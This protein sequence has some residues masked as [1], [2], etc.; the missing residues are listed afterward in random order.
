MISPTDLAL[1]S[2]EIASRALGNTY[3]NPMVGC[4][5]EADGQIIAE[6]Y[7]HQSGQPHAEVM[8]IQQVQEPEI[9][10]K[11]T[12]FVSLEPCVHYG[13]TPPCTDLIIKM[14]IPRVVVCSQDPN[15]NVNGKG[16]AALQNAGVNVVLMQGS[17]RDKALELNKRFFCFHKKSRPYII[18]KWA[19]THDGF[20]DHNFQSLA[21]SSP[22]TNQ[23]THSL[24][25]SEHAILVGAT[26]ALRDRPSLSTRNIWGRDPIRILLDSNLSSGG[27]NLLNKSQAPL[28]II[29]KKEEKD[30]TKLR[31]LKLDNLYNL[32]DLMNLFYQN[33]IQSIL[34]EGGKKLLQS[35]IDAGLW[36]EAYQIT[37]NISVNHGTPAPSLGV[38]AKRT[39]MS[40]TDR[41][42]YFENV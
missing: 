8:A 13:K 18:L 25:A 38:D 3:P 28:W 15:S 39:W 37:A 16:I 9:L 27:E 10:K 32:S 40:D 17:I 41:I 30:L 36:D 6:G 29:N 14:G 2:I 12:L 1:R 22:L 31:Y 21:I 34:V 19:Q 4:V 7:H 24:R 23:F 35:F 42:E 5:I 11:S 20:I 26:T 33:Q